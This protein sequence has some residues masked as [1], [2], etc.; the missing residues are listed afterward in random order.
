MLPLPEGYEKK[1]IEEWSLVVNLSAVCLLR[2]DFWIESQVGDRVD[3]QGAI[4]LDE[5]MLTE[6]RVNAEREFACNC[7][8]QYI[9]SSLVSL[10][11]STSIVMEAVNV[12][13]ASLHLP[14]SF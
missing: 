13:D 7:L 10:V 14:L 3:S 6:V 12:E 4:I 1:Y 2:F 5:E 11:S 9:G 8:F